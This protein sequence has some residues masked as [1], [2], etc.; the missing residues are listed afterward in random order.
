VCLAEPEIDIKEQR[1][2]SRKDFIT[3]RGEENFDTGLHQFLNL[4]K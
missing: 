1:D 4:L 3:I 2:V